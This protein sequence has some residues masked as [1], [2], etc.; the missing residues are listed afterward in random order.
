MGGGGPKTTATSRIVGES[1]YN[2]IIKV[3]KSYCRGAGGRLV[4]VVVVLVLVVVVV[5]EVHKRSKQTETLNPNHSMGFR[6]NL[7]PYWV[8]DPVPSFALSRVNRNSH[9]LELG[10]APAHSQLDTKVQKLYRAL[11]MTLF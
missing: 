1:C 7:H 5:I 3:S 4:L 6:A 11:N 9:G 10:T 8:R 2:L